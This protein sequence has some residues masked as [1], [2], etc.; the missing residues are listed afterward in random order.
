MVMIMTMAD[1]NDG[2]NA[3]IP[4][5]FCNP[6]YMSTNMPMVMVTMASMVLVALVMVI[7]KTRGGS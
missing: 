7:G 2:T 6:G 4:G 3:N 5:E 1:G